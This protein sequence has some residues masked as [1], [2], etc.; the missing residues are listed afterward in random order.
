LGGAALYSGRKKTISLPNS[1]SPNFEAVFSTGNLVGFGA[2]EQDSSV[3]KGSLMVYGQYDMEIKPGLF[4]LFRIAATTQTDIQQMP[5]CII[6]SNLVYGASSAGY[7]NNKAGAAKLYFSTLETDSG[8]TT[9]YRFYKFTT[10]PTGSGTAIGG[11]YETQN[12]IFPNKETIKVVRIYTQPLAANNSFK[13]DLIDSDGSVITN[14]T[15]T[16]TSGTGPDAIGN[17]RML[18]NPDIKP[19]YSVGVRITNLGTAAMTIKKIELDTLA[20]G[21]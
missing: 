13:I 9:K 6:V 1:I 8:P 14:S 15:H 7:T 19:V 10:V 12:Q 3:L 18:Y 21:H 11:V 2:P 16:F 5:T 4:R 17:D 20:A